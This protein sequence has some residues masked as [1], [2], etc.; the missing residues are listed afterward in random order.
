MAVFPSFISAFLLL[1]FTLFRLAQADDGSLP[2]T[3]IG[4]LRYKQTTQVGREIAS[5]L[6]GNPLNDASPADIQGQSAV[7]GVSPFKNATFS[8]GFNGTTNATAAAAV[9]FCKTSSDVCCIWYKISSDLTAEFQ[10]KD[11]TCNDA[12]RAS[13]RLGF[14]DAGPWS[15]KLANEGFDFGG[16]DGSLALFQ[17]E[18][19][20]PENNGLQD[21]I[22]T[23]QAYQK[24]YGVGMADLIQFMAI[25]ATVTCTYSGLQLSIR[26]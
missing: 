4:D 13:I 11:G 15:Q 16:A 12:A 9:K 23:A 26:Y 22:K 10:E 3:L 8:A 19:D 2:P 25:H 18:I 17:D 5:I 14:H 24:R 6:L 7:I 21:I 1:L 20:R